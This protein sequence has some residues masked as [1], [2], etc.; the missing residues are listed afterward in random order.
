MN[1]FIIAFS[2]VAGVIAPFLLL[3]AIIFIASLINE[4]VQG[5][6]TKQERERDKQYKV[7]PYDDILFSQPPNPTMITVRLIKDGQPVWEESYNKGDIK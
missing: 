2:A 5:W 3:A 4:V 7:P 1:I 6:K